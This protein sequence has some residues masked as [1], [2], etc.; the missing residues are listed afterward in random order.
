MTQP[1]FQFNDSI[2][3]MK[4]GF[5]EIIWITSRLGRGEILK[6]CSLTLSGL[7][8]TF[9]RRENPFKKNWNRLDPLKMCKIGC[10]KWKITTDLS[11]CFLIQL[12]LFYPGFA[13]AYLNGL[14]CCWLSFRLK[15]HSCLKSTDIANVCNIT[16]LFMKAKHASFVMPIS[17]NRHDK[18]RRTIKFHKSCL[19]N[20]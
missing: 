16:W 10:S 19:L 3:L 4:R 14:A 5:C 18:A 13:W 2:R 8:K 20:V 7:N 15:T 1:N 12:P 17:Q 6:F 9:L 11:K